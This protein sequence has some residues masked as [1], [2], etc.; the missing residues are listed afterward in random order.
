MTV[1]AFLEQL[2]SVRSCGP[3]R[4][5]AKCPSH[6]DKSPSLSV[7]EGERGLLVHCFAGCSVEEVMAALN[8]PVSDLFHDAPDSHASYRERR[9]RTQERQRKAQ[10]AEVDGFTIDALRE[11]DYLIRTR[12]GLDISS[13]DHNH[14][15]DE[16]DALA[17]AHDLLWEEELIQWM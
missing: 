10:Y 3:E 8:L 14:L 1:A 5:S 11:A 17:V 16:L 15:H 4:W 12:Q 6:S 13:W 2:E 7:R 9:R